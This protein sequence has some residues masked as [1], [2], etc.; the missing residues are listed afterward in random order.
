MWASFLMTQLDD[1]AGD[2]ND[3]INDTSGH[4]NNQA[5]GVNYLLLM[6]KSMLTKEMTVSMIFW[7]HHSFLGMTWKRVQVRE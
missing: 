4:V 1:T 2:C 7:I 3:Q 5:D 6:T